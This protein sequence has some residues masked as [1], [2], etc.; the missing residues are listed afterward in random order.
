MAKA[1]FQVSLSGTVKPLGREFLAV[2]N[3][4]AGSA[5]A[6]NCASQ[7]WPDIASSCLR[8]TGS[9]ASVRE[10]RLVTARR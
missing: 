6:G 2:A 4:L 1:A 7:V 10:V 5:V 8:D 9:G 3:R